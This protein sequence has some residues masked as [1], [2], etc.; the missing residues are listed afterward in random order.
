V[1][2]KEYYIALLNKF[3]AGTASTEE[4]NDLFEE[5]VKGTNDADWE[6]M[7]RDISL[8]STGEGVYDRHRWQP[9]LASVLVKA[10]TKR[11][12]GVIRFLTRRWQVAA[13]IVAL[14][15]AAGGYY[16]FNHSSRVETTATAS[17]LK[18]QDAVPGGYKAI[19]KLAG[20]RQIILDSAINGTLAQQGNANIQKLSNGQL[21]YQHIDAKQTSVLYNTL[22]TP[23]GGQYQLSLPDGTKV[24]L[25]AA[26]SITYPTAFVGPERKVTISGEAYLEVAKEPSHPFIVSVPAPTKGNIEGGSMMDIQVLGTS[27]NISAYEEDSTLRTTLLEGSIA[28]KARGMRKVIRPLQEAAIPVSGASIQ[29]MDNANVEQA[30]AWKN[31][32]F[33]F[34]HEDLTTVMRQLSRWYDVDV[35]YQDQAAIKPRQFW[36]KMERDLNLS[37]VLGILKQT[38]VHFTIAGRQLIVQP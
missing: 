7:I 31:G 19:L 35:V 5:L 9:I 24:W 3:M 10:R 17:Q 2:G 8:A 20:G 28:V 1:E 21:V 29:V 6:E 23:R 27:F 33:S 37:E 34:T 18:T 15:I 22:T 25:N 13:A 36:G 12:S 30:V 16:R 11:T 38:N 26:S 4:Q 32:F 14:V